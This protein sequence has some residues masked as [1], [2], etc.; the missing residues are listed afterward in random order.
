MNCFIKA[1]DKKTVPGREGDFSPEVIIP[2]YNHGRFL[3]PTLGSIP[4]GIPISVINDAST[5]DTQRIA[6]KLQKE[7]NFKLINNETN[8]NQFGSL[9]KAISLSCNNLFVILNADDIFMPYTV[10]TVIRLFELFPNIRMAGGSC[11]PFSNENILGMNKIFQEN[12]NYVPSVKIMGPT[13]AE[14]YR[15]LNDINMTMSSCTFLKSAWETVGGFWE[16][17]KRVCSPDDR[18]FQ[19]RVSAVFEVAIIE[20]PLC[21]Y[22]TTSSTQR[23]QFI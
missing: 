2:C 4:K 18:D 14:K 6:E 16:F 13:N 1:I 7:F 9:N 19:M 17:E 23:G 11:I 20:E 21:F 22:R 15:N 5:D 8:L 12:L 10:S 3:K